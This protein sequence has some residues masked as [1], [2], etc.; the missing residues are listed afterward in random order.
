MHSRRLLW[1]LSAG[2]VAT[3]TCVLLSPISPISP[4]GST[5]ASEPRTPLAGS[6]PAWATAAATATATATEPTAA[7]AAE[8]LA[9]APGTSTLSFT[10]LLDQAPDLQSVAAPITSWLTAN[11][12]TPGDVRESAGILP[13]TGTIAA[14]ER[15]FDTT[16]GSFQAYGLTATAPDRALSTPAELTGIAGVSGLVDSD[17]MQPTTATQSATTRAAVTVPTVT[18]AAAG[19]DTTDC[20]TF[21][22]ENLSSQWP[23]S[24]DVEHRSNSLCGYEPAQLRAMHN[25]PEEYTGDG[26]TIAIVAAYDDPAVEANTNTYF[27]A[28]GGQK[29][30]A[31][32][33]VAH[34]P[35]NPDETRCGGSASWTEEQHLD[36]QAVHAM[37]PD[38][39]IIYWGSDDCST[40]SMFTRILDAVE[41]GDPDVISL[42]FG[43]TEALDTDDDRA[44]LNRVLVEAAARNVSVFASTGN[45]GDYSDYGDHN[46]GADVTSPASSPYITAVGGTSVGLDADDALVVEAGWETQTR[47]ARN[48]GI[49]PPGFAFG[50]GGGESVVYDRPTWQVDALPAQ[51]GSGRLLPDVAALGDPNTGFSVYGP[52]KGTTQYTTHGGTSLATPMVASMVAL[53]KAA[54]GVEV[55]L[56]TPYLYALSGTDAIRDVVPASAGTFSPNGPAGDALWPETLYMWDTKPQSLQSAPGWDNVTGLGVPDGSSFITNFG[57][58]K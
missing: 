35:T 32:Q 27:E 37:A 7:R 26:A 15:A 21:W 42:S 54:T 56:A 4:I 17:A 29:L 58:L 33:Y 44:L 39:D 53:A 16:F 1:A 51:P 5:A 18:A 43:A 48:G 47:F 36:V 13:V 52:H 23:A 50:S 28:T 6:A 9:D 38:A 22:G 11:D 57:K 49:I 45:D 3:T 41:T 55:G 34:A 2:V 19:V 46:D 25:L 31:G 20:A 14:V 8:R 10:V 12:L 24:V 40:T 30:R